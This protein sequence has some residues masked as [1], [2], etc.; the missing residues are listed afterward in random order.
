MLAEG[1]RRGQP[2][3]EA[4]ESAVRGSMHSM[5][6]VLLEKLLNA[7]GGGH[8]GASIPC[9]RGHEA[10]FAGYREKGLQTVLGAIQVKRAYYHCGC[11]GSGMVPKDRGLDIEGTRFSPGVRRMIGRVG[12]KEAF[13]EGRADLEELAGVQVTA[14]AVERVSEGLGEQV[15]ALGIEERESAMSGRVLAFAPPVPVLYVAVDGTGVPVLPGEAKG[16]AG[17]SG[18]GPAK[19]REAKLGCVFT[20]TR[21]DEQGF[22][23]RDPDST[24][25]VGAIEV[26]ENCGRRIYAEAVRRGCRQAKKVVVLGDGA[27]WI[28]ALAEEHFSGAVQIIDLYHVRERLWKVAE[29]AFGKDTP[30]AKRWA[31]V[32]RR[33]LDKGRVEGLIACIGRLPADSDKV[34]EEL[35]TAAEYFRK[36]AHRMRYADFRAQGLFVGSGVMEAGC[37]IVVGQRLKRSG[38]RWTVR[39]A[40]SIIALRC[41]QLS[42]RWEEFWEERIPA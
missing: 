7:D 3:L 27:P 11:C 18:E 31:G 32:Q 21:I 41:C 29:L 39:G 38:M 10:F 42:N 19:T 22:P 5:G 6:A 12:A 36:N 23:E 17:K 1:R 40:N 4:G 26:A 33:K 37:K 30:K 2:D 13:E 15:E 8:L 16:R 24:S 20:Q 9:G 35:T 34:R 28:W 25:C 14:K